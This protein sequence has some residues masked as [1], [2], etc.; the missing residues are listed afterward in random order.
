MT[1]E[2]QGAPGE[3]LSLAQAFAAVADPRVLGR[4]KYALVDMLVIAVCAMVCG[5]EDFVGIEAWA[6][7]RIDWLRRF[8][9]LQNG[10]P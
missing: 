9:P 5:V 10:V 4:S 1:T 6:N 2:K 8:L 7:E 3:R